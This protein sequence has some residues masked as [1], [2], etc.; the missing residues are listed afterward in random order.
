MQKHASQSPKVKRLE[1]LNIRVVDTIIGGCVMLSSTSDRTLR[2]SEKPNNTRELS[3]SYL[4]NSYVLGFHFA[5]D[6]DIEIARE[7][8]VHFRGF[9]LGAM[10]LH[11]LIGIQDI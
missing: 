3:R 1:F 8:V 6:E 9:G 4:D 11:H 7:D 5:F 2:N 10:V